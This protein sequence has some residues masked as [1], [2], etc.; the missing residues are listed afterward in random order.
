MTTIGINLIFL[1]FN[2]KQ[3]TENYQL[4]QNEYLLKIE[5]SAY[6]STNHKVNKGFLTKLN[7]N[8]TVPVDFLKWNRN[9]GSK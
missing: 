8:G 2:M 5:Y 1:L 6:H 7:K 4:Q 3:Y 9:I